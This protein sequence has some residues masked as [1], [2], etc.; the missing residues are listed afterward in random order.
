MLT[1]D[2]KSEKT[3]LV[4]KYILGAVAPRPIAFAS[5]INNEGNLNLSPFSFFNAFSAN[6]P[7]LIFSPARRVRGNTIK[8]T[9]EN[10]IETNEVVIGIVTA[11]M[12]Q[13]ASLSSCDF[14]KGVNEFEKAGFTPV[15]ADLTKP[16]LI[17]ESPVNFECKVNEVIA[18]GEE[19]G[20][21]NLVICEVLKIHI[22]ETILDAKQN[23]D[24]LKLN[25]LS[26]L[27]GNWYGRATKD[28]L[29]ELEKPIGKTAMGFDNLPNG[30]STSSILSGSDL[31]ILA[32]L[33]EIPSKT[34]FLEREGKNIAE[35]HTLAKKYLSQ[36]NVND[37]WQVLL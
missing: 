26:R 9:L 7:V 15:K 2:P 34:D 25:A 36:G 19:G 18:L 23:I 4:H 29:F 28:N 10:I 12:A 24:P 5:T 22:K 21:G 20:A 35:K 14:D 31:A 16:F 30:I 1:I 13:Q 6:P 37:A 3:D 17:K 33:E 8:H 11:E 27:G 32:S